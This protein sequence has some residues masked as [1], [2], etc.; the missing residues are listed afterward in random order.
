MSAMIRSVKGMVA[1]GVLAGLGLGLR[2]MTAGAIGA[3]TTR[4]LTSM[5]SLAIGAVGWVAYCWLLIA[6]L[7]TVLEQAPG[8]VGRSASVIAG[9]ITS[10]GSRALL[11][12]ALGV[13]AA[14]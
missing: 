11:R 4:D 2:W 6:A 14:T 7:A 13:A 1:L 9:W 10:Q 12:S 3:A 8:A 5:A